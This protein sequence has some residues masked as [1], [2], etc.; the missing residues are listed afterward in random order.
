MNILLLGDY[1][2]LDQWGMLAYNYLEILNSTDHNVV[3]RQI[4]FGEPH[5]PKEEW[6]SQLESKT[7]K[8]YDRIIQVCPPQ[9]YNFG[10][11]YMGVFISDT[12]YLSNKN[13][14]RRLN[15]LP[16]IVS[17]YREFASI[18]QSGVDAS[19]I[20]IVTPYLN[21]SFLYKI[22]DFPTIHNYNGEYIFYWVG[23]YGQRSNY[24]DVCKAFHSTFDK[25]DNVKLVLYFLE[26]PSQ[27]LMNR[28]RDELIKIKMSVGIFKNV[29]NYQVEELKVGKSLDDIRALHHYGDCLVDVTHGGSFSII[30]LEAAVC[31]TRCISPNW[32]KDCYIGTTEPIFNSDVYDCN[33]LWLYPIMD[34]LR[35]HLID[36]KNRTIRQKTN[37][38]AHS[39]EN[40]RKEMEDAL[41]I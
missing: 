12:Y 4:N 29:N 1:Y 15:K 16:L 6:I 18:E 25:R 8:K 20:K 26:Q 17:T 38:D 28:I 22:Y 37:L 19:N 41:S 13:W 14:V 40:C 39:L 9:F 5:R 3:C 36:A 23:E 30:A 35:T 21:S 10:P 31:G 2:K 24:Q 33:S 32:L 11:G 27:E 34:M 7:E